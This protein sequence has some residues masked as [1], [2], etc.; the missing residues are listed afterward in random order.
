MF[1]RHFV[2]NLAINPVLYSKLSLDSL[3]DFAP[4][5]RVKVQPLVRDGRLRP[6]QHRR[7]TR[8]YHQRNSRPSWLRNTSATARLRWL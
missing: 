6:L 7:G 2:G 5:S 4:I 8:R 1:E 3:K